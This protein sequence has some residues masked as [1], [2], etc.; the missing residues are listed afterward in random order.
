MKLSAVEK[1]LND[2]DVIYLGFLEYGTSE[3]DSRL[4]HKFQGEFEYLLDLIVR[5]IEK[6][7][8]VDWVHDTNLVFSWFEVHDDNE[9]YVVVHNIDTQKDDVLKIKDILRGTEYLNELGKEEI[10][11]ID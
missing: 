11:C 10:L 1:Y 3:E 7:L 8:S 2:N 4:T 9:W 6:D 5:K